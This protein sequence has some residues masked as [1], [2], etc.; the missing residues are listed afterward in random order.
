MSASWFLGILL[1]ASLKA[2]IVFLVVFSAVRLMRDSLPSLRHLL[3]LAAI[4]S[5]PLILLLSLFGPQLQLMQLR[6]LKASAVLLP[7]G[8][9]SGAA[10]TVTLVLGNTDTVWRGT[11]WAL[12]ALF[13]WIVGTLVS[14][15]RIAIGSIRLHRLV[16][17]AR[18]RAAGEGPARCGQHFRELAEKGTRRQVRL[19]QSPACRVPF[20]GGILHP[21]IMLPLFAEAW[22]RQRLQAVLLHE[23]RHVERWDAMT[24]AVARGICSLFWFVPLIWIACSF[25]YAE[26]EKACDGAVLEQGVARSDYAACLLEAAQHEPHPASYAGLLSLAWR[27]RVLVDRIQR[28]IQGGGAVKKRWVFFASTAFAVCALVVVGGCLSAQPHFT[29]SPVYVPEWN[30][31]LFG[32]W[33]N[34]DYPGNMD[35]PQKWSLYRYGVSEGYN[36]EDDPVAKGK[37]T[38]FFIEKWKDKEGNVWYTTNEMVSGAATVFYVLYKISKQ[39]SVLENIWSTQGYPQPSELNPENSKYRIMYRQ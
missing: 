6:G 2:S 5:Y 37:G 14:L 19:L 15:L 31:E 24:Q 1:G 23:L 22:P 39:G 27:K 28:I 32:N 33:V 21:F 25:L 35:F 36:K 34:L 13:A 8:S 3:W 26:Q 20:T 11:V 10:G 12:S 30:E 18:G 38:F 17:K 4:A 29:T 9:A 16:T 7:Q